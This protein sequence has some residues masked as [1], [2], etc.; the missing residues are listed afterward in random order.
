M[1]SLKSDRKIPVRPQSLLAS[2]NRYKTIEEHIQH[3]CDI[4]NLPR[5]NRTSANLR[6]QRPHN[7]DR[8][9][10]YIM[11]CHRL[12]TRPRNYSHAN[13]QTHHQR[14]QLRK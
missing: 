11:S 9:P 10:T 5:R 8:H 14:H 6:T 3:L 12:T 2:I 4:C 7:R 1:K 13:K